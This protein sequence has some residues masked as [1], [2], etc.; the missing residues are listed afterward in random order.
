[1]ITQVLNSDGIIDKLIHIS[2]IHI[3]LYQRRE[4]YEYVFQ[5]LY[6]KL[7][8]YD[9]NEKNIIVLTG[10]I[11][12]SKIELSPECC[13]MTC[14]F[15]T[16]LVKYY[17][18]IMIAG[19][20]DALLNNL[21]RM[22][23]ISSIIYNRQ[24][25]GLHYLKHTGKYQYGNIDFYV[26]SL[27]DNEQLIVSNNSDN[28]KIGLYHGSIK[29]WMNNFGFVSPTG[30][31]ELDEFNGLDYLLLGD[32]HKH[33]YMSSTSAYAGS[34][35]SQNFGESDLEH[36][37]LE[38]DLNTKTQNFYR[39]ENPYRHMDI[40]VKSQEKYTIDTIDYNCIK[41]MNLPEFANVKIYSR[42]DDY[43]NK[44]LVEELKHFYPKCSFHLYSSKKQTLMEKDEKDDIHSFIDD[45]KKIAIEYIQK[46]VDESLIDEV[47]NT[48]INNWSCS[49]IQKTTQWELLQVK[50]SNMFS[51]GKDNVIDFT[52]K[53]NHGNIIGIFGENSVGK[54]TIVE[55]ITFLLFN[56]I[57]RFSHG[58]STPK[59]IINFSETKASGSVK[60]KYGKDIYLI[61]KNFSRGKTGKITITEKFFLIKEN[62]IKE[63]L[64][65]EQ[66]KETDKFIQNIIG[67]YDIFIYTNL[68]LQQREKSFRDLTATEKKKFLYE[69]FGYNWFETFEK[70]KKEQLKTI[71]VEEKHLKS[72]I[73][74][75][76]ITSYDEKIQNIKEQL[77]TSKNSLSKLKKENSNI[78]QQLKNLYNQSTFPIEELKTKS[79]SFE[80][81]TEKKIIQ[82]EKSLLELKNQK[83]NLLHKSSTDNIDLE[84]YETFKN[85]SF[86]QKY[87]PTV[88][89]S[90][91]Q[92]W[93][94]FKNS[95][96]INFDV[97]K[98]STLIQELNDKIFHLS[99]QL[100][101]VDKKFVWKNKK[102]KKLESELIIKQNELFEIEEKIKK[103]NKKIFTIDETWNN[104][105]F[106]LQKII[107]Q[108][109]ILKHKISNL[110]EKKNDCLTIEFNKNCNSCCK[111]PYYLNKIK[112]EQEIKKIED[113]IVESKN[114]LS[115]IKNYF[116][117][118]TEL[119]KTFGSS[120][121]LQIVQNITNEQI[122]LNN[123]ITKSEKIYKQITDSFPFYKN[124]IYF[125]E[126]LELQNSID[127]HKNKLVEL[128]EQKNTYLYYLQNKNCF[129]YVQLQYDKNISDIQSSISIQKKLDSILYE[130][131]LQEKNLYL[132]K[133]QFKEKQK[134][135]N[136]DLE[137]YNK[138]ETQNIELDN[139]TKILEST[140]N[141][142]FEIKNN[143]QL[144]QNDK[145]NFIKNDSLW[146]QK[147]KQLEIV[148]SII[149]VLDKD[150][151]PLFLLSKKVNMIQEQINQ[152]IQPFLSKKIIFSIHK[153]NIE[154]GIKTNLDNHLC[155]YLGGME[156]FIIDLSFKLTF[157]KF[158]M[159]PKSNFFIIDE[160]IS[161]LDQK[162]IYNINHLFNFLSN[163]TSNV[164]LISHIPQ[165]KDWVSTS[166]DIYK[167]NN[168]SFLNNKNK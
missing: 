158:S 38:W 86:Y 89:H 5:Q 150:G 53:Q 98:N 97:D 2:D 117:S 120:N 58:N 88:E 166:L 84:K 105:I 28:L 43:D 37:Y 42:L 132:E 64:T 78:N 62:D 87:S 30:E 7:Q 56:K 81:P 111:N 41:D 25:D 32:I 140:N 65:G 54:S 44:N 55:I 102:K 26:D 136:L 160:G 122:K 22:D 21:N 73:N 143:L 33:Q 92:Q 45:E 52:G 82:L 12:H 123:T 16:N 47:T 59:E 95:I 1:M 155:N 61:T 14:D 99:S 48:I 131:D 90:S 63:E 135:W 39:L 100:N 67:N 126:N 40:F 71:S 153:K 162:M 101:N 164:L 8:S 147:K 18:V 124:S 161:V 114:N 149:K 4:E 46:N 116:E 109:E 93:N 50:F 103:Y 121:L 157:S 10:D 94:K 159:I 27:L 168:H 145:K 9:P 31:K 24:I 113:L 80:K 130:I 96:D 106:Q 138:I 148:Q 118:K 70:E 66:K 60:F 112:Y 156:S 23:S 69:I 79:N 119:P 163:L 142:I 17:P 134:K 75:N 128:S 35:I 115:P 141:H 110:I 83:E 74:N 13:A 167:I 6:Q 76:C 29:G 165:I 125:Y 36:G 151:L 20:H 57:T 15:F 11:L 68:F 129:D 104:Y 85:N 144:I 137:T 77:D 91:K 146:K 3:R 72:L 152:L 108:E 154:V 139:N 127:T 34:L 107:S 133:S 49:T 51:Y 19:N